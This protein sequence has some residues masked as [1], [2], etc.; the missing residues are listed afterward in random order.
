MPAYV[1]ASIEV[2]NPEGYQGYIRAVGKTITGHGGEVLAADQSSR[3]LEGMARP[4]TVVIRFA[5]CATA[6]AWY[7]SE[8]Y[9]AIIHLRHENSNGAMVI[10]DGVEPRTG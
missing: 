8:D 7:R 3:V 9:Q 4:L 2:T 10:A 5:D 6:D 1:V